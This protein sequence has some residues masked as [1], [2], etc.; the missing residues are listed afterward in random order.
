MSF[1]FFAPEA[2]QVWTAGRTSFSLHWQADV[3]SPVIE[4]HEYVHL[5]SPEVQRRCERAPRVVEIRG[6]RDIDGPL[7]GQQQIK[8]RIPFLQDYSHRKVGSHT[9]V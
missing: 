8:L 1:N 2:T 6:L 3:V 7:A 4:D 9:F 5:K